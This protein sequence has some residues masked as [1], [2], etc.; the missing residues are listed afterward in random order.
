MKSQ[1]YRLYLL[2][3][4]ALIALVVTFGQLY[5]EVFNPSEA[6][7][8]LTPSQLS[9]L[10]SSPREHSEAVD[11]NDIALSPSLKNE[12]LRVGLITVKREHNR[13]Y[14]ILSQDKR[15][16]YMYGPLPNRDENNLNH[17]LIF[18]AFYAL[19]GLAVLWVFWPLFKDLTKLQDGAR[20]FSKTA[21]LPNLAINKHSSIYPLANT[22]AKMAERITR[23]VTLHNDLSRIIS[24]EIR[25]PL[26]RI[27]F[28]LSIQKN[29]AHK[30][31]LE[32]ALDDIESRLEQYL[33][34]ARIENQRDSL[35][36]TAEDLTPLIKQQIKDFEKFTSIT[37]NCEITH[38]DVICEPKTLSIALQNMI[39]NACKYANSKITVSLTKQDN[40]FML[41]VADD[42]AGLPQNA[43]SLIEPFEQG[44]QE[45]L[46]SGYG[47]GLYIVKR[48]A[49]WH[50]GDV[51]LVKN[52]RLGGAEIT[53]FWPN[54]EK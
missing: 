33:S 3:F 46:A 16:I 54:S 28:A 9:T 18:I 31:T 42:G 2:S 24:H 7:I 25:T 27:R 10:I 12:L 50:H 19:L 20:T 45:N 1:F 4:A 5:N 48:I 35:P 44:R 30:E 53:L 51:K 17:H 6:T 43:T 32:Q 14:Y 21:K 22:F 26:S 37:F 38:S 49:N 36:M 8:E 15:H 52:G 40:Q 41:T 13:Y 47:L 39:G 29:I 34:F 11:I 23:F